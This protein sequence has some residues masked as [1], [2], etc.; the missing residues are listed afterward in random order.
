VNKKFFSIITV[1]LNAK[2]D[3]I[4]TINSLRKQDFKDFEYIVIDG[5][6]TD[7]TLDVIKKNLDIIDK[8][9][10][11]KDLG[12]YDAMNKGI[13]L[14]EGNFIGIINSGDKYEP[15]GLNIINSYLKKNNC[16]F[17]F[18]SVMKKILRYG[19]RKYRIYWNFDFYSSHSSGFFIKRSSQ[20]TLGNYNIKYKISADYDLFYRM[21]IK[22][23]MIGIATKQ[24]EIVGN[25]KSGTSY[26][27]KFTFLEHLNEETQIRLD[28]K[29][30]IFVV[31]LVFIIHFIKNIKK[32]DNKNKFNI[33]MN[34]I[35]KIF[36]KKINS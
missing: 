20:N 8:W 1:V 28:N 31:I 34:S 24:N 33:L 26:S 25:F 21:I 29:Q 12:I 23:K 9:K 6:S 7:G 4:E 19:Y 30:N 2:E 14:C 36:N 13:S 3:L 22:E 32:I 35:S 10:S 18:G 17:I 11:E 16:D 5:D 27:S 15:D